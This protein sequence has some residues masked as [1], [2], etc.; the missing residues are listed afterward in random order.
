MNRIVLAVFVLLASHHPLSGA[1]PRRTDVFAAGQAGYPIF[2][3]PSVIT[4]GEGTVLAFAEGR[5]SKNDHA[6]NDIVLRRSTDGGETWQKLQVVASHGKDSLNNPQ[7]VVLPGSG[8]ILFMYQAFPHLFHSRAMEQHGIKL[9]EPGHSGPRVQRNFLTYSDDEGKTWSPA[10]DI[11]AAT[12]RLAPVAQ[13]GGPG[14]GIVL[15]RGE[16]TGRI[17]MP[18]N[19]TVYTD[20]GQ[21]RRWHVYAVY[22]DN[23]GETWRYGEIAPHDQKSPGQKGWGNEVQM[24]ELTDGSVMLNSRSADGAKV[25]K[26]AISSDGGHSWSPLTD[27][28]QLPEPQC[29]GSIIRYS[30]PLDGEPSRLLYSGPAIQTGRAFGMIRLSTDDGKTWSLARL[31]EPKGF[32]YSVLTRLPDGGIGCLYETDNYE[33][34]VFARF[35][36]AWLEG[37]EPR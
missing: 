35:S 27:E 18:F 24:V 34:I 26:V 21:S 16:H 22:S 15:R 5:Q 20:D 4:T 29:M 3:I 17:V 37:R 2:R 36:L 6:E 33:R 25:R 23:Q 11:T 32:A 13:A 7:A 19:E 31:L 12:K 9:A 8:R 10:R 28:P 1:D 14:I 30:D